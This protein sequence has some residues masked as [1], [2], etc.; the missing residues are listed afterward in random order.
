[1]RLKELFSSRWRFLTLFVFGIAA[2]FVRLGFWQIDRL[3]T[4]RQRVANTLVQINAPLLTIDADHMALDFS[5]M[6]YRHVVVSGRYDPDGEVLLRNQ[7]WIDP[8]GVH[9]NGVHLLTP[10][11]I[12]G[13]EMGV[14]VDRGW[15]P[16]G[17]SDIENRK[18]YAQPGNITVRGIIRKP[19]RESEMGLVRDP[20]LAPGVTYREIWS[21]AN[22]DAMSN[23][24][25]YPLIG[26]YIQEEPQGIDEQLP[27]AQKE[28]PDLTEGAHL[29]FA[30]QWFSLAAIVIIGYPVVLRKQTH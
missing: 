4:R 3:Q 21:F 7:I 16:A 15:I 24:L 29:G 30:F 23:Q 10:L 9:H 11:I 27:F 20:T 19:Q 2:I 8:N 13:S 14:L 22:V 26:V 5:Q 6:E 1:M 12:E 18:M 25:A 17:E 28:F